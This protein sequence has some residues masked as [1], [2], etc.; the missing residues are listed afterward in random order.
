MLMSF[1]ILAFRFDNIH[2]YFYR[3]YVIFFPNEIVIFAYYL[4]WTSQNS[5]YICLN[6]ISI[7]Y[8]SNHDMVSFYVICK[9]LEYFVDY[10]LYFWPN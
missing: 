4:G 10:I 2:N 5:H 7:Y 3:H 8:I 1:L 6:S 9:E